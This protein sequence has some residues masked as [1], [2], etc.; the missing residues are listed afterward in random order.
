MDEIM[1]KNVEIMKKEFIDNTFFS[2]AWRDT[3]QHVRIFKDDVSDEKK[4]NF[5][6]FVKKE[7]LKVIEDYKEKEVEYDDHFKVLEN[8]NKNIH[9]EVNKKYKDKITFSFGRTQKLVNVLLKYYWCN[10]ML[11]G[12]APAHLPIDSIIIK[13]VKKQSKEKEIEWKCDFT[14]TSMDKDD[15]KDCI[16]Q[17]KKIK[18]NKS[19]AEWELITYKESV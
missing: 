7:A 12:H 18:G 10:S 1:K 16:E 2:N 5:R 3:S 9:D 13:Q 14:W 19:F 4:K 15:Y 17:I 11:N 6:N 8:V